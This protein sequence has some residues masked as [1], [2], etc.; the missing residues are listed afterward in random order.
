[1]RYQI[2]FSAQQPWAVVRT[3]GPASFEGF[4]EIVRALIEHPEWHDRRS[5]L[6]DHSALEVAGLSADDIKATA[7]LLNDV[8]ER[9]GQGRVA[10]VLPGSLRFGLGRMFQQRL[11]PEI[12]DNYRLFGTCA[13][14]DAWLSEND[15]HPERDA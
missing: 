8:R 3:E 11:A 15:G 7:A 1:M 6:L 9:V 5:L 4:H 14:A 2:E 12:Q 13:E 10:I